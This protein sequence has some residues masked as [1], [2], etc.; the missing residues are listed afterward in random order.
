MEEQIYRVDHYLAKEEMQNLFA[1]RFE[2]KRFESLWNNRSIESVQITLS[3]EIGIGSR[4]HFW[5]ETGLLRDMLQSHALQI[6]A[7]VALEKPRSLIADAIHAEKFK[8]CGACVRF[9]LQRSI[10]M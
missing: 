10:N 4:E 1:L 9:H 2:D 3:E 7:L 5:E 6:L 8:C